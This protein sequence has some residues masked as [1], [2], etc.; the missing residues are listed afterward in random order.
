[1]VTGIKFSMSP[2][3]VMAYYTYILYSEKFDHYY[4]GQT[5]DLEDRISKH[6]SGF[7][8][9]SA[10]YL[11]WKLYAYKEFSTRGEAFSMERKLK[12]CKSRMRMQEFIA[13]QKF[14]ILGNQGVFGPENQNPL[15]A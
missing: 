1:M 15:G 4:Y 13:R 7:V 11:P 3:F 2:F 8:K 12:N 10:R 6:N 9:S 14:A 5:Q